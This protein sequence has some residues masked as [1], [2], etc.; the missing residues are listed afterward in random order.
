[1]PNPEFNESE[2]W[3]SR[4][5]VRYL[6]LQARA[7]DYALYLRK[8]AFEIDNRQVDKEGEIRFDSRIVGEDFS[9]TLEPI[10]VS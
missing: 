4:E 2:S 8:E 7:G 1:M 10:F 6:P 9:L 3:A 5:A